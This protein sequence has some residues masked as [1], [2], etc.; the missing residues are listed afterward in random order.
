MIRPRIIIT[1]LVVGACAPLSGAAPP[2]SVADAPSSCA[3]RLSDAT[4]SHWSEVSDKGFALCTPPGWRPGSPV[5][6]RYRSMRIRGQ[7]GWIAWR[8]V[9]PH[10][11]LSYRNSLANIRPITP[12]REEFWEVVENDEPVL[13]TIERR[14]GGATVTARWTHVPVAFTGFVHR[15][16][17]VGLLIVAMRTARHVE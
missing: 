9:P 13:I 12:D 4:V 16:N 1:L 6:D 17:D 7:E 11:E 8:R 5:R 15:R 2:V 14:D 10:E 3:V